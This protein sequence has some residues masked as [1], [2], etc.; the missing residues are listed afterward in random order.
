MYPQGGDHHADTDLQDMWF[1]EENS[2]HINVLDCHV[3]LALL[4]LKT[5]PTIPQWYPTSIPP[6]TATSV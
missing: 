1:E 6:D 2:S 4:Q 3:C 5:L